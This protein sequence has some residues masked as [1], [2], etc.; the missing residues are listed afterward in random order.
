M[1]YTKIRRFTT[2]KTQPYIYGKELRTLYE[3]SYEKD[4][5]ETLFVAYDLRTTKRGKFLGVRS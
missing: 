2:A 5:N 3:N 1:T 4:V